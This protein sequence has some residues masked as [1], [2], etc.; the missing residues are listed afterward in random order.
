MFELIGRY[1]WAV[2]IVVAA[3]NIYGFRPRV[4]ERETAGV[5]ASADLAAIRHRIFGASILPWV[6]MGINQMAGK[7]PTVRSYFRPQDLN[8]YVWT[9]YFSIFLLSC[10]FSYWVLVRDGARLVIALNL[11]QVRGL[12]GQV[13]VNEKWVKAFAAAAPPFTIL[14]VFLAWTM[15]A[16]VVK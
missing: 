4:R 6:L 15:D 3:L 14:W 9:W 16:P 7:V 13:P 1:F 11:V 12:R 10:V 8:P 5:D 2:C